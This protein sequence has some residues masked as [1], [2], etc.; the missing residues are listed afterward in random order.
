M[1]VTMALT[2]RE[3][4]TLSALAARSGPAA[5]RD[6]G[7]MLFDYVMRELGAAD[8]RRREALAAIRNRDQLAALQEKVRRVMT[9]GIGAFPQRTPLNAV[10]AGEISRDG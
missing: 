2:R 5:T 9:T 3:M 10:Q 1:P 7:T 4:L 6:N 8:R